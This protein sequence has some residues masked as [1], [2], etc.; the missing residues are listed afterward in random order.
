MGWKGEW[1]ARERESESKSKSERGTDR[2]T[3]GE[4]GRQKQDRAGQDEEAADGMDVVHC[5]WP[6]STCPVWLGCMGRSSSS[7]KTINDSG[8][9]LGQGLGLGLG[10]G[11]A[12]SGSASATAPPRYP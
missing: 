9:G 3:S 8:L 10:L 7:S 11:P 12:A 1:R 5:S 2:Q 4:I 6:R